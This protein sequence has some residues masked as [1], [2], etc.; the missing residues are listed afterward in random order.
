MLIHGN[1]ISPFVRMCLVTAHE[2]GLKDRVQFA[3]AAVTPGEVNAE[4]TR[5][6]PIGKKLIITTPFTTAASSWNT[7]PMWPEIAVSFLTM[8]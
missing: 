3:A 8:V 2:V 7:W 6:S 1:I 4:L 5:L